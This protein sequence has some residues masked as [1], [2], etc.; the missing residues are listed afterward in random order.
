MHI[1]LCT[2][3]D[4]WLTY[5][6]LLRAH[7]LDN[8]ALFHGKPH[9]V[10]ALRPI[11]LPVGVCIAVCQAGHIELLLGRGRKVESVFT[12][13]PCTGGVLWV[14]KHKRKHQSWVKSAAGMGGIV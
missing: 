6:V 1:G 14:R 2:L 9:P 8:G 12:S 11:T 10:L 4:R 5:P 7:S 13:T 3:T